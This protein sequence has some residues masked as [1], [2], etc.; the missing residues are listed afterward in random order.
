MDFRLFYSNQTG[1]AALVAPPTIGHVEAG[2][3]ANLVEFA[4]EVE[5][6]DETVDVQEVWVT[7]S[8][9]S[10]SSGCL[11][12]SLDLTERTDTEGLWTGTLTLPVGAAAADVRYMVQ[13]AS[14]TGLISLATNYGAFFTPDVDPGIT[15][16]PATAGAPQPAA[17]TLTLV[18]APSSGIYAEPVTFVAELTSDGAPLAGELVVFG[19][20][21]QSLTVS[22]DGSGRA[23]ATFV[24][25]DSPG[26]TTLDISYPGATG[27]RAAAA[28]RDFTIAK[29]ETNLVVTV[30]QT[31]ETVATATLT[32]S[33]GNPLREETIVFVVLDP[34]TAVVQSAAE[35]TNYGGQA[36]FTVDTAVL[37]PGDY[38][39]AAFFGGNAPIVG[40]TLTDDD[41]VASTG[42]SGLTITG[43]PTTAFATCGGYDVVEVTPGLYDAPDFAGTLIVGAAGS[44]WLVG[45]AGADLILGLGAGDKIF[46]RGGD[47]VICGNAGIDI[48]LG[49]SGDDILFGD[50]QADW[51][52]G[53]YGADTLYGGPGPDDL[54]GNGGNDMLYGEAGFD[55]LLGGGGD[56]ILDAGDDKD[57]LL[58]SSGNDTLTGGAGRDLIFGGGGN[59][60]LFGGLD[61]DSLYGNSGQDALDGESGNDFCWGGTGPDTIASCEGASAAQSETDDVDGADTLPSGN[62]FNLNDDS[63]EAI[64][65]D[66][67]DL[68]LPFIV[69]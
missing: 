36:G 50:E 3:N 68:H 48:I 53:G 26:A 45:T 19:L 1:A 25:I 33:A 46:G 55:V 5:R 23:T 14:A 7:Y 44:D 6:S 12:R 24:L 13:A 54:E 4:I 57:Y 43:P 63:G 58:G 28:E 39:V 49:G 18:S 11:W 41:Y 62:P 20:G 51:L 64:Q 35:I 22:T 8:L 17:T 30:V 2:G 37:P 67:N 59:D 60:D 16:P 29:R 31:A 27:Y 9:T 66:L 15:T 42:S 40:T 38:T 34:A 56:D 61:D 52:I 21:S 47:D 65:E 69:R 10:C 32:D